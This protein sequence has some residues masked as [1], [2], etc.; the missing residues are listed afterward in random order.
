MK[1]TR[2]KQI[3]QIVEKPFLF[4]KINAIFFKPDYQKNLSHFH[5][6][7]HGHSNSCAIGHDPKY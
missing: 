6:N 1:V 7:R 5:T 3:L 2:Q 4:L